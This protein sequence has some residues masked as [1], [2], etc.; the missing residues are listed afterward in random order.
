MIHK[1][2]HPIDLLYDVPS[3]AKVIVNVLLGQF[4]EK[5]FPVV[6]RMFLLHLLSPG[7]V[8]P[9]GP[10]DGGQ[11]AEKLVMGDVHFP[12]QAFGTFKGGLR[13]FSAGID[14]KLVVGIF[15]RRL[16]FLAYRP[17]ERVFLALNRSVPA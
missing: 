6:L 16:Y 10:V 9:V 8:L 15:D 11:I 4:F 2:F 17:V 1:L 3:F 12:Y 7:A 14:I 5:E 13:S